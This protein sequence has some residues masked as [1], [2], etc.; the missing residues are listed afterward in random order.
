MNEDKIVSSLNDV[1]T[2][3]HV[4]PKQMAEE[5]QKDSTLELVYQL[6]TAGEKQKTPAIAKIKSKAVRKYLLQFNRLTLKK[7]VLHQLYIHNDVEFH[8]MVLLIKFQAQRFNGFMMAKVIRG[9]KELLPYAGS[10]SIGIPCS[11]M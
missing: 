3:E 8:Q 5:Q 4:T 7:G 9:L 10:N 2:F 11:K 6:V 1:S